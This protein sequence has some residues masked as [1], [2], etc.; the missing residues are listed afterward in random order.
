MKEIKNIRTIEETTGY[1]AEDGKF[2]KTKEECEKYEQSAKC[3]IKTAFN[4]LILEKWKEC[5]LWEEY[6][7]G[8]E[9]YEDWVI[10]IK[11]ENDLK[12]ANQFA[13]D[14]KSPYDFSPS[15][16]GKRFLVSAGCYYE[17]QAI[18]FK[19]TYEDMIEDFTKHMNI[20]FKRGGKQNEHT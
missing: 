7:Y 6:G 18:N 14:T 12:V 11:D 3:A 13:K 19:R 8:G 2:F 20:V 4:K 10:E 16:I 5:E 9:E 17:E 15:D 1:E